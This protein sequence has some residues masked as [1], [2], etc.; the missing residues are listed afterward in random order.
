M[1]KKEWLEEQIMCDDGED[2]HHFRCSTYNN[3][4]KRS[5]SNKV[6]IQNQLTNY[7]RRQ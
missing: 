5:S 6:E 3:D 1:T 4:K 7:T 2:H